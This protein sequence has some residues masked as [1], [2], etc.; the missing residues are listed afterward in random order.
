MDIKKSFINIKTFALLS[1]AFLV[2]SFY[3]RETEILLWVTALL[4]FLN[5]VRAITFLFSQGRITFSIIFLNLVQL[6]LFYRLHI[7]IYDL[8]GAEH[9]SYE[10]QP[11]WYDWIELIGVHILRALDIL[12]I[13]N[14]Y[15]IN[16]QNL[17]AQSTLAKSAIVT[18]HI[19]VDIFL[20][21]AI[22][23]LIHR[24]FSSIIK[25]DGFWGGV[26]RALIYLRY[27]AE[28]SLIVLIL[29]V[30]IRDNWSW[31]DSL[32]W[33]FE[34]FLRTL[35]I[36]DA[37]EIF[38]WQLHTLDMDLR[39][40]TLALFFRLLVSIYALRVINS[41]YLGLS[42]GRGKTIEEL[43]KICTSS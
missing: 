24:H 31:T 41:L 3:I 34:N 28:L 6:A 37:F 16:L 8:L 22:I 17:T 20:M 29:Y 11:D 5:F 18:M 30:A 38:D 35:D 32:W 42:K 4:I 2:M 43:A 25:K 10:I 23:M 39:M 14:A 33:I 19:M 13:F 26:K 27:L 12:D 15:G 36:G 1:V 7:L 9:Y 21:G 40:E